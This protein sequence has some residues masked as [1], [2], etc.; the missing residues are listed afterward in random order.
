MTEKNIK[1]QVIEGLVGWMEDLEGTSAEELR[2]IRRELGHDVE[3]SEREFTCFLQDEYEKLGIELI[4]EADVPPPEVAFAIKPY[5]GFMSDETGLQPSKI[6]QAVGSTREFLI[7]ITQHSDAVAESVR[8]EI[9]DRTAREFPQ[10]N[11]DKIRCSLRQRSQKIAAARNTEYSNVEITFEHILN[12]TGLTEEEQ[13]FWRNVAK[14]GG[15]W[16]F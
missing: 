15:K 11:R 4:S 10:I 5:L 2:N 8:E 9:C 7:Q 12:S 13:S 16:N 14:G 1:N 6:A 3:K